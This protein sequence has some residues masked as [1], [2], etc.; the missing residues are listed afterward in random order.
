MNWA[1][2]GY[3][4][5]VPELATFAAFLFIAALLVYVILEVPLAAR[6]RSPA[7]D[8]VEEGRRVAGDPAVFRA[9]LVLVRPGLRTVTLDGITVERGELFA[10]EVGRPEGWDHKDADLQLQTW[11]DS[12]A[13]VE[14]RV[15]DDVGGS[16][17]WVSCGD[18]AMDL[19]LAGRLG[20][21]SQS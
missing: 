17:A 21:P 6:D 9:R 1:D 14:V 7:T 3:V 20:V 16:R 18:A 13:I 8:L 10:F 5:V 2:D 15:R 12:D 4:D 11:A 19:P